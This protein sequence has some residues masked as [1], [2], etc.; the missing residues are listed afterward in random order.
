MDLAECS[1]S[2]IVLNVQSVS[3]REWKS[4]SNFQDQLNRVDFGSHDDF[5]DWSCLGG[6]CKIPYKPIHPWS[7][8]MDFVLLTSGINVL[9]GF[10]VVDLL[11]WHLKATKEKS[12]VTRSR[13]LDNS[14]ISERK[15]TSEVPD[16][17]DRETI[18]KYFRNKWTWECLLLYC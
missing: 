17:I 6:N 9:C 15:R 16:Q 12:I 11:I 7:E 14:N 2:N 1:S 3:F 4:L 13:I 10:Q 8:Q 18:V 5:S